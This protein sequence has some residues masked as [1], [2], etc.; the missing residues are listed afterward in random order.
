M[1]PLVLAIGLLLSLPTVRG[2]MN[3]QIDA[4]PAAARA[5]M[6]LAVAWAG[7]ALVRSV[8][9]RHLAAAAMEEPVNSAPGDSPPA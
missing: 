4:G 5:L 6:A 2:V 9:E 3:G 7:V 1:A 8:V